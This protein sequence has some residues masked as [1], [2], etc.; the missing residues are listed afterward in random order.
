MFLSLSVDVT[1]FSNKITCTEGNTV[2]D[3]NIIGIEE[4]SAQLASVIC[5]PFWTWPL[6]KTILNCSYIA[7]E[8]RLNY[9]NQISPNQL[10]KSILLYV[11]D[12][13]Y[14][15]H[16]TSIQM[17]YALQ[18]TLNQVSI[19]LKFKMG[20]LCYNMIVV[21]T[22]IPVIILKLYQDAQKRNYTST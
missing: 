16:T 5:T 8:R 18:I 17:H 9:R 12:L 4:R 1:L 13:P 21:Y 15:V 20:L 11:Q 2:W 6:Q 3:F 19:I 14:I 22:T 7:K 10:Q